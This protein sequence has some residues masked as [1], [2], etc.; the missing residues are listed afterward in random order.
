MIPA[1]GPQVLRRTYRVALINARSI[2]S[3][4]DELVH[5][6]STA[7]CDIIA[8]TETWLHADVADS[9][10]CLLGYN[11]Y[12]QDR[13]ASRYGGVMLYVRN[14]IQSRFLA[15]YAQD[16]VHCEQLWCSVQ[17]MG[18]PKTTLGVFYRSPDNQDL[19]WIPCWERFTGQPRVCVLGDFNC[20]NVDWQT[21]TCPSTAKPVE[22]FLLRHSVR[23]Q[24]TQYV[25]G[26]TRHEC[27]QRSSCLDLVLTTPSVTPGRVRLLEPLGGSDHAIV[28]AEIPADGVIPHEVQQVRNFW[29]TDLVALKAQ[30]AAL[31]W[32]KP[33]QVSADEVWDTLC[34]NLQKL[35][36][37]H[38]PLKKPGR[39]LK[40][41]P[42]FDREVLALLARR[43]RAWNAFR[44]QGDNLSHGKYKEV[45]NRCKALIRLKKSRYEC[46]LLSNAATQPER[47]YAYVNRRRKVQQNVPVLLDDDGTEAVLDDTKANLLADHFHSVYTPS[48]DVLAYVCE[49]T[50][51]NDVANTIEDV[52]FSM[53]DV[54]SALERLDVQKAPGPDGMH[55]VILKSLAIE[56]APVIYKLFRLSLD[57]AQLPSDWKA[58]VI[59]PFPKP[60]DRSN[61]DNYRPVCMTSILVKVLERFVR[62]AIDRHLLKAPLALPC[63]HGFVRDRS[64][65]TNLLMARE[66][67]C[68]ARNR[69][70]PVHAVFVDFSKAFDRVDHGILLQK[71]H[72]CG[73]RGKIIRWVAA[74]LSGRSW[75]VRLNNSLSSVR[76]STSGVPQGSVL[77]PRLFTIYVSDLPSQLT[78]HCLLYADDLKIWREVQ[79]AQDP[80]ELQLDLDRLQDWAARNNLPVNPKKCCTMHIGGQG[81]P[82]EYH[83]HG[84]TLNVA[85]SVKDLGVITS[86]DLKTRQHTSKARAA[87]LKMLW[88]LKRSFTNWSPAVFTLLHKTF[89]RP[90]MEYGAPA[91]FPCTKGEANSLEAVQ[92]L[93]TRMVP[94][95]R[96]LT[97]S[98]RCLS[99]GLFTLR[100]R[101]TRADL[102][103]IYRV[104]VRRDFPEFEGLFPRLLDSRTRGHDL[105]IKVTRTD[106][107]PHVYRLS[108]RAI[109]DWNR[110]PEEAVHATTITAFK[111]KMDAAFASADFN[112]D[113]ALQVAPKRRSA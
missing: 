85:S 29:K 100:Y 97:Y 82:R 16:Q 67:W 11:L 6:A 49:E 14:T 74:Y 80:E 76:L 4:W 2:L 110:L 69:R 17:C 72:A 43:K 21:L 77:G 78:S 94:E 34:S 68:E 84:V 109:A 36:V 61:P 8:V 22:W 48:S 53:S 7:S 35:I 20:P 3:K 31:D 111:M 10:L 64:C 86:D 52:M 27:G 103:F 104:M 56:L 15:G 79:S 5:W 99:L 1:S 40:K 102:I 107:L 59:R 71:L 93:G 28:H 96:G 65:T 108:R 55:P 25:L 81:P 47:V 39:L 73:I 62:A 30:A 32:D 113:G 106:N 44:A 24:L 88:A 23:L 90:V 57:T 75:Q 98:D 51:S 60:G 12:R 95:L 37:E 87:G 112:I 105:R 70:H 19:S 41:P 26:C 13:M 66:L 91:Y 18:G 89:I 50:P 33:D 63:Q 92:R 38:V 9:E 101:R 46:E 45:R 54:Q 83:I 58:G 42:W